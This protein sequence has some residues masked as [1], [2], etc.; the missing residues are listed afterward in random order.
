MRFSKLER[1]PFSP[2]KRENIKIFPFIPFILSAILSITLYWI[3]KYNCEFLSTPIC[4]IF[5]LLIS[6]RGVLINLTLED[7]YNKIPFRRANLNFLEYLSFYLFLLAM[8]SELQQILNEFI[9]EIPKIL[10]L[11]GIFQLFIFYIFKFL[12]HILKKVSLTVKFMLCSFLY[13]GLN[14]VFILIFLNKIP[15][16]YKPHP[17]E[18]VLEGIFIFFSILALFHAIYRKVKTN[19][20]NKRILYVSC[21]L[22]NILQGEIISDIPW[23]QPRDISDIIPL[24]LLL[25]TIGGDITTLQSVMCY[26]LKKRKNIKGWFWLLITN[27]FP[28]ALLS[29]ISVIL[30]LDVKK[31]Y[32]IAYLGGFFFVSTILYL[33]IQNLM[34]LLL[35]SSSPI[36]VLCISSCLR[37]LWE[38]LS[39]LLCIF[40]ITL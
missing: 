39:T 33:I 6:G 18:K 9:I 30:I 23:E 7:S 13:L 26:E 28:L 4:L 24:N 5:P 10:F 3:S 15:F 35:S 36:Y 37:D 40:I 34:V 32:V 38:T 22:I 14:D 8:F 16:T 11:L 17:F 2:Q 31:I 21:C 29:Y 27:L 1:D 12:E 20:W 25:A 19:Y